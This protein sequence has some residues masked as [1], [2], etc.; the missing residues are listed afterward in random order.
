M[1][2]PAESAEQSDAEPQSKIDT[3]AVEKQSRIRIPTGKDGERG[4]IYEPGIVFRYVDLVC[5]Y[6]LNYDRLILGRYFLLSRGT[7]ITAA[8]AVA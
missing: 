1:P 3:G 2:S 4:A 8:P 5:Y 6:R 7:Q